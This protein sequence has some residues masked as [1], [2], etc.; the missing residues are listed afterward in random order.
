MIYRAHMFKD[1]YIYRERERE[2][3]KTVLKARKKVINGADICME[4]QEE[5]SIEYNQLRN[6]TSKMT[7]ANIQEK[8][9]TE[10]EVAFLSEPLK[11]L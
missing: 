2:R 4:F 5:T 11:E 3:E 6:W 7:T 9:V 1:I 8:A 10:M